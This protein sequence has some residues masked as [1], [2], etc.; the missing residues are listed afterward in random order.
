MINKLREISR[1][2][3][4]IILAILLGLLITSLLYA[5]DCKNDAEE[6]YFHGIRNGYEMRVV[7]GWADDGTPHRWAE[8]YAE[9]KW[10]VWDDSIWYVKKSWNTAEELGYKTR[11]IR[12]IIDGQIL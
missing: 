8:Y 12:R 1:Y 4:I 2:F 9:G 6:T 11:K 5:G 7:S 10:R 3:I